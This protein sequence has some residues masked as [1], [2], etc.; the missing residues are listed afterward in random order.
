MDEFGSWKGPDPDGS[1]KQPF[2]FLDGNHILEAFSLW[3]PYA[4]RGSKYGK[5]VH[6]LSIMES[7]RF[8][9]HESIHSSTKSVIPA[10]IRV[11][12]II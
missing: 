3:T 10:N 6:D 2:D 1:V 11:I 9:N 8:S 12:R 4:G 7:M 5:P